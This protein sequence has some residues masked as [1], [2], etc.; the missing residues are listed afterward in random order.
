MLVVPIM[1]SVTTNLA[2][3]VTSSTTY[4]QPYALAR[5]YTTLDHLTNVSRRVPGIL[6]GADIDL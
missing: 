3:G 5:R 2:F 4:E 6:I 1:A